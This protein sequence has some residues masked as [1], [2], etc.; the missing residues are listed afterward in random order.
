MF[1]FYY[2][3]CVS[4]GGGWGVGRSRGQREE[5]VKGRG[6]K[7]KGKGTG[8][9][10]GSERMVR[11][12]AMLPGSQ[13]NNGT[14]RLTLPDAPAPSSINGRRETT[15]PPTHLHSPPTFTSQSSPSNDEL[16]FW[17]VFPSQRRKT[18]RLYVEDTTFPNPLIY[19][20]HHMDPGFRT[21]Q[22]VWPRPRLA[23][24]AMQHSGI[25]ADWQLLAVV[26]RCRGLRVLERP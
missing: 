24:E 2:C 16:L 8:I 6:E 7:G 26:C 21:D 4:V 1:L 14:Q 5:R 17:S 22:V 3:W 23:I 10:K 13:W 18:P 9:G 11:C 25:S 19:H 12:L 15:P 20:L